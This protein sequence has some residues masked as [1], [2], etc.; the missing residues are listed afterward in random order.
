VSFGQTKWNLGFASRRDNRWAIMGAISWMFNSVRKKGLVRT[1]KVATSA[2]ADL[3]FDWRY[4][5]DTTRWVL[6][7]ELG[8]VGE[9]QI[10]S[11]RYQPTKARPLRNLLYMLDLPRERGFVDFGSGKGRVLLIAAQCGFQ[12]IIGVEFSPEL[13]ER[14]RQN[15]EI[16][17]RSCRVTA[18]IDVVLSDVTQ[19]RIQPDQSI[20]FMYNPFRG[21][22]MEQVV[23]NL[24][25]SVE[26]APRPIW[27]IYNT[28][29][30]QQAIEKAG[31]FT[32]RFSREIGGTHFL[33]YSNTGQTG[34]RLAGSN[35]RAG[36]PDEPQQS[37][38][39]ARPASPRACL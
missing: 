13:C 23:A 34:N 6:E 32:N 27:L 1:A 20:F 37:H 15:V 25:R 22:V 36:K 7:D 29:L 28:P 35:H 5:T 9:N 10:H 31:M 3:S 26:L 14:T 19:Y 2:I 38:G 16:F 4:G 39:G 11:V 18:R 8:A 30:W 17:R 24:Q 33:I 12:K 21:V